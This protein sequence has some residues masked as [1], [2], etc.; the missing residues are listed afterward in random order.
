MR[1]QHWQ[2]FVSLFLG[3]WLVV[4]PLALQ[5]GDAAAW[6]SVALG[7]GVMMFAVEGLLIPSYLEELGE[8]GLG[9]AL[10]VAPWAIGYE[11]QAAMLS[12][13]IAGAL[14]MVLAFWEIMTDREC[15]TWW[16]AHRHAH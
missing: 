6:I 15:V 4:S 11:S 13:M 1:I 3:A 16:Q 5:F 10:L 14:V 12:S 7:L 9:L 8:I 2:D